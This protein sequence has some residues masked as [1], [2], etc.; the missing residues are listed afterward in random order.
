MP[1]RII[2]MLQTNPSKGVQKNML[3]AWNFTKKY[4]D[5]YLQKIF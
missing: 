2:F 1:Q 3:K 5:N 4:F